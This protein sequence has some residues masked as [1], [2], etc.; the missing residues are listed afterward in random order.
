M[1]VNHVELSP[2]AGKLLFDPFPEAR[3]LQSD[4]TRRDGFLNSIPVLTELGSAG[5]VTPDRGE[6]RLSEIDGPPTLQGDRIQAGRQ[7][8]GI[9]TVPIRHECRDDAMTA[10]REGCEKISR[11]VLAAAAQYSEFR[12]KDE[13]VHGNIARRC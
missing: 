7:G 5:N 11:E 10:L 6:G 9:P 2:A 13:H 1:H 12:L 8:Q 4:R 3:I